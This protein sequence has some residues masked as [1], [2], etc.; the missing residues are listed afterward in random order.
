MKIN[1]VTLFNK[2]YLI[3]GLLL[4]NSINDFCKSFSEIWILCVDNDTYQYLDKNFPD[5]NLIKIDY[6]EKLYPELDSVKHSRTIAEYCW[7]LTPFAID[8]VCKTSKNNDTT[9][10]LDADTYF[11][12][13]PQQLILDF[14]SSNSAVLITR[15][16]YDV[17]FDKSEHAGIYCVQ[18]LAFKPKISAQVLEL[19]KSQCLDWC[20]ARYEDGKF[21]DQKYLDDWPTRFP[22]IVSIYG[23]K[24]HFLAPWNSLVY[25]SENCILFHFHDLKFYDKYYYLG[26]YPISNEMKENIY[27]P[28][29][30]NYREI[31][32][33]SKFDFIDRNNGR[34]I[35]FKKAII[36]LIWR[37]F[38]C[39]LT[40]DFRFI[41][42]KL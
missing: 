37:L 14:N 22:A 18:L 25:D 10:Y 21:G 40:P 17:R 29:I 6:L 27:K 16:D 15:H 9:I 20:Y 41:P 39:P 38:K 19:W 24:G 7:T 3:Q 1:F 2:N 35:P 12:K 42:H 32:I 13:S 33:N 4:I 34:F 11:F 30:E 23:P 31:L 36:G 26:N 8:Y 5:L 28:Y